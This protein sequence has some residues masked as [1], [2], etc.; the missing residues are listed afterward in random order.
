MKH[1]AYVMIVRRLCFFR[2]K[3]SQSAIF[4]TRR[5]N[6]HCIFCI[7]SI[8]VRAAPP[9]SVRVMVKVS[10]SFSFAVLCFECH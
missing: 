6:S 10:V 4:T 5:K 2:H 1:G 8:R 9:V 3:N 7:H